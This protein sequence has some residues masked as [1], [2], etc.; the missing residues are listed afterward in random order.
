MRWQHRANT[1]LSHADL[2][3]LSLHRP[4]NFEQLA[5]GLGF[6]KKPA[7]KLKQKSET[8]TK[9]V[10]PIQDGDHTAIV[11]RFSSTVSDRPAI[12]FYYIVR[13]QRTA[14]HLNPSEPKTPQWLIAAQ[15][16]AADEI[17]DIN[18]PLAITPALT[19]AP[20]L[21]GQLRQLLKQSYDTQE[22]DIA[23]LIKQ[24]A[25]GETLR[26]MPFTQSRRRIS[27]IWVLADNAKHLNTAQNDYQQLYQGLIKLW[28]KEKIQWQSMVDQPLGK[29]RCY[30]N[31]HYT[32]RPWKIPAA[33]TA[34]IILSD[35]GTLS[36]KQTR[37]L[38]QSLFKQ[39]D[40]QKCLSIVLAPADVQDLQTVC[41]N[42]INA[43]SWDRCLLKTRG[44]YRPEASATVLNTNVEVAEI[45]THL[46]FSY[47]IESGLL[48]AIR[49]QLGHGVSTE[50]R[51]RLHPDVIDDGQ[52]LYI[53]QHALDTYRN[54]F[55]RLTETQQNTAIAWVRYFHAQLPRSILDQ[56]LLNAQQLCD[57][58]ITGAEQSLHYLQRLS[59]TFNQQPEKHLLRCWSHDYLQE[60]AAGK[61]L[62]AVFFATF[63]QKEIAQHKL[64]T[65]SLPRNVELDDLEPFINLQQQSTR[66]RIQQLNGS[67]YLQTTAAESES[68]F[69]LLTTEFTRNAIKQGNR[70]VS[71]V[72]GQQL[73]LDDN[74]LQAC[75]SLDTGTEQ[76]TLGRLLKPDWAGNMG[77][78]K[79][80]LF[81]EYEQGK[82]IRRLYYPLFG[83]DIQK[84]NYGI[85]I[86]LIIKNIGQRFRY[87]PPGRFLMGS[88]E[89]EPE[90]E[91]SWAGKE[92]QHQVTL[93]EGFWLADTAVTQA[94][95]QAVMGENPSRFNDDLNNPVEMVSWD[96][97]QQFI[98]KLNKKIPALQ[99]RLPSEAQWEYACRTGTTA[100]FTFGDTITPEQVNYDGE[101]PYAKGEKGL[102]RRQTVPVKTLSANPWGLYEMHGNVWEWCAD[103]YQDDLGKNPVTDPVGAEEGAGRVVRGGSWDDGGRDVR[104]AVRSR[105]RPD[106]RNDF[107]GLRLSLGLELQTSQEHADSQ[108]AHS[109]RDEAG[110]PAG[111]Q[112]AETNDKNLL[113][114]VLDLVKRDQ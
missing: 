63:Y 103:W 44:S 98:K 104:S 75:I 92:T 85:Y 10:D 56:E 23:K 62:G 46:A 69:T 31:N 52:F 22:P 43:F 32:E 94:L 79:Q 41:F 27:K 93:T 28:G 77:R 91:P 12:P 9:K 11:T 30:I 106:Y 111:G 87:I 3:E 20:R 47:R 58:S 1:R 34:I 21:W 100:P 84:D 109:L 73:M 54:K 72:S 102:V 7:S 4:D 88:P 5:V 16:L 114:R 112:G 18:A 82:K 24:I 8:V 39:L 105:S 50:A 97:A 35:C 45:L 78:D 55:K 14:E 90:R 66:Y 26:A 107:I 19:R 65:L 61:S 37:Q 15:P 108:Q 29:V 96:D 13:R 49:L 110:V 6:E 89:N 53:R 17:Y 2:L 57:H 70:L 36:E 68:G 67:L 60:Q 81:I 86:D 40:R 51:C 48:R 80:G 33:D 25:K 99:A 95:Y 59:K 74:D 113:R 76:L 38:W 83:G 42:S 64:H 101:Y 71:V